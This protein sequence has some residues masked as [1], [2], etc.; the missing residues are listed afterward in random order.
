[1]CICV[2]TKAL[3]SR[4]VYPVFRVWLSTPCGQRYLNQF[5]FTISQNLD[6]KQLKIKVYISP[7]QVISCKAYH[8]L[9]KSVSKPVFSIILLL[10]YE[11]P[12]RKYRHPSGQ[13]Q[14]K[15]AR[16]NWGYFHTYSSF[17]LVRISR[18]VGGL[19]AFLLFS[20]RDRTGKMSSKPKSV[21]KKPSESCCPF[22]VY[23]SHGFH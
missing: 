8:G 1:M 12:H 3:A 13:V 22:I 17:A 14:C 18:W 6:I 5:S 4:M 21:N 10:Q 7:W 11:L 2:P 23:K 19:C 16:P 20:V 9:K 15:V